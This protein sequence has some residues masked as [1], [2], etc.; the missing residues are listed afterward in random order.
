MRFNKTTITSLITALISSQM[1]LAAPE[2]KQ[3]LDV[4]T[5][6]GSVWKYQIEYNSYELNTDENIPQR[7][8]LTKEITFELLE[9]LGKKKIPN[10]SKPVDT[11][12]IHR[13]HNNT[14][15]GFHY[16]LSTQNGI[17]HIGQALKNENGLMPQILFEKHL[18]TIPVNLTPGMEWQIF[19]DNTLRIFRAIEK[20]RT[21]C[22]AGSFECIH[23][24]VTGISGNR[25]SSKTHIFFSEEAGIVKEEGTLIRLD[26]SFTEQKKILLSHSS[27]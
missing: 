18:L 27:P 20:T 19:S 12:S 6:K 13:G 17:E 23:I 1:L 5:K 24:L 8:N 2:K 26:G 3:N 15:A 9:Y 7:F 22:L 10:L 21:T 25:V 4:F 16:F 14:H 11:L